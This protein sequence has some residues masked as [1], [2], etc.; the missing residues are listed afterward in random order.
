MESHFYEYDRN[1]IDFQRPLLSAHSFSPGLVNQPRKHPT[2]E[3][4]FLIPGISA[5]L[6][7]DNQLGF[8]HVCSAPIYSQTSIVFP[9]FTAVR[10]G[11]I[12]KLTFPS[13]LPNRSQRLKVSMRKRRS[14]NIYSRVSGVRIIFQ[15]ILRHLPVTKDKFNK[16]GKKKSNGLS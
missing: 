13:G 8:G 10:R 14:T 12:R 3:T 4:C 15:G 16:F 1:Y 9:R 5:P 11:K 2:L 6:I 7:S